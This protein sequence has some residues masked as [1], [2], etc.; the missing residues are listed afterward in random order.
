MPEY[1][2]ALFADL[3]RIGYANGDYMTPRVLRLDATTGET[4][5]VPVRLVPNIDPR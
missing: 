3:S 1:T 2:F 4:Q 5:L